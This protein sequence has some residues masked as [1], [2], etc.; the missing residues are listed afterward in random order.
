MPAVLTAVCVLAL[1]AVTTAATSTV[2]GVVFAQSGHWVVDKS[3]RTVL[4]VHGDWH[5]FLLGSMLGR[6]LRAEAVAASLHSAFHAPVGR[7]VQALRSCDPIF[8]TGI[9]ECRLLSQALGRPA[10]H[11][12]SGP[13]DLFFDEPGAAAEPAD[14]IAVG[15]LLPVKHLDLLLQCAAG[16]DLRQDRFAFEP[17]ITAKLAQG[18][19]RF[20]EVG[21]S[22]SCRTYAEGKKIRWTDGIVA[23]CAILWYGLV[24]RAPSRPAAGGPG[25]GARRA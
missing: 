19:W 6:K 13:A 4:H 1:V 16:L 14:V 21:I 7:Y 10:V 17:E 12:P 20:F 25:D 18:G 2:P 24:A 15:S 5:S 22:Y 9:K 11:L 23:V 3:Q 8:T